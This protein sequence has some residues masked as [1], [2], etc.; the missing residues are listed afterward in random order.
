MQEWLDV[1]YFIQNNELEVIVHNY[2][3]LSEMIDINSCLFY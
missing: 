2:N 3:T 1:I